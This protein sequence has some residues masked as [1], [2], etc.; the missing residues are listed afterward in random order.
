MVTISQ[1]F[2]LWPIFQS[3]YCCK[4]VCTLRSYFL[5][6]D[7]NVFI[8]ESDNNG[9]IL[10]KVLVRSS[11]TFPFL[12]CGHGSKHY[13]LISTIVTQYCLHVDTWG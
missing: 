8:H 2:F 9:D 12:K 13:W 5:D 1:P 4:Y 7:G 3:Q 6:L 10:Y 11:S